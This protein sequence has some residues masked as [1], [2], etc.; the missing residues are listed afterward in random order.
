MGGC[1]SSP[2]DLA[3]NEGAPAPVEEVPTTPKNVEVETEV[4]QEKTQEV[5]EK[6]EEATEEAK[7]EKVEA[8]AEKEDAKVEAP[9]VEEIKEEPLVTL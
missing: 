4:A 5:D 9:K 8:T 1:V 6:K 2:K 7:P 3:L